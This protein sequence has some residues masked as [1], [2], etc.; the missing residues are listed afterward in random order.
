[1]PQQSGR[2][3]SW[4]EGG[5]AARRESRYGW[6]PAA[7]PGATRRGRLAWLGLAVAALLCVGAGAYLVFLL[8]RPP[9]PCFVAVAA[10]PAADAESLDVPLDLAGWQSAKRFLDRGKDWAS[11]TA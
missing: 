7:G 8:T 1:M 5:G 11:R 4:R 9:Q 10:D 3:Q 6:K 2:G